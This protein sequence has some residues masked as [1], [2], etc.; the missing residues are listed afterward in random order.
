MA[1][2]PRCCIAHL[3]IHYCMSERDTEEPTRMAQQA[4]CLSVSDIE[5]QKILTQ[6]SVFDG[7][8][9]L[10]DGAALTDFKTTVE[11]LYEKESRYWK[12]KKIPRGMRINKRPAFSK[13]GGTTSFSQIW[14]QVLNKCSM[15]SRLYL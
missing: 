2:Y 1:M 12:T 7:E 3:P 15:V 9:R 13:E 4:Q 11:D 6:P 14:G 8:R 5:A 10:T